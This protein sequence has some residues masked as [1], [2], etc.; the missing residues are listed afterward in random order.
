M[1]A[2]TIINSVR[3][4]LLDNFS[5]TKSYSDEEL[6][7]Y[8]NDASSWI[9]NGDPS[10][11]PVTRNIPLSAGI[12]QFAG[13]DVIRL[14]DIWNNDV[15]DPSTIDGVLYSGGCPVRYVDTTTYRYSM[16]D[17]NAAPSAKIAVNVVFDDNDPKHFIVFPPNDGTGQLVAS[18][19]VIPN[20]ILAIGDTLN[21]PATYKEAYVFYVLFKALSRDGEDQSNSSAAGAFFGLAE[22]A[23]QA[24]LLANL[25]AKPDTETKK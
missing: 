9:L 14:L 17:W 21:M 24:R 4:T 22:K 11:N 7:G 18:V 13:D 10:A 25:A 12:H 8:V 1:Q 15:A 23:I 3:S 16:Q 20:T 19:S 6:I 2:I 5:G